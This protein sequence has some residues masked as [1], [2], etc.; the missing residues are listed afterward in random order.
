MEHTTK[1][2]KELPPLQLSDLLSLY[3]DIRQE[4][5]SRRE[6]EYL[7]TGAA[8][9]AYGA[10]AW[11]IAVVAA[12]SQ[13][14]PIVRTIK[15][16]IMFC[17]LICITV[18]A[19]ITREHLVYRKI[20]KRMR[21]VIEELKTSSQTEAFLPKAKGAKWGFLWSIAIVLAGALG[22]IWFCR[23][24]GIALGISLW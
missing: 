10:V 6:P 20:F 2:A 1:P 19:K 14:V 3:V 23:S 24:L 18:I 4:L 17:G 16:A 11:G 7:Y 8:I 13:F 15:A 21:T 12:G 22:A 9:A 5:R